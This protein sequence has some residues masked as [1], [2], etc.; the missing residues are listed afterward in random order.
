MFFNFRGGWQY[1]GIYRPKFKH[2][3]SELENVFSKTQIKV[4]GKETPECVNCFEVEIEGSKLLHSKKNGQG[5]VDTP[6]KL[7]K[8]VQEI[9]EELSNSKRKN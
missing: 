2:V 8:I 6:E 5:F 3:K 1:R 9:E 7:N 4:V